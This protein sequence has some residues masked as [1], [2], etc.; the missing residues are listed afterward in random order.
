MVTHDPRRVCP[1]YATVAYECSCGWVSDEF[2]SVDLAKAGA[3]L[4]RHMTETGGPA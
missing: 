2:P 4:V 3:Q 1:T